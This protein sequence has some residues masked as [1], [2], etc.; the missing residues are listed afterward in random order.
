V[1]SVCGQ[2]Y[3]PKAAADRFA[4]LEATVLIT[5]DGYLFNG[6]T[7]DRRAASL[8]LARALPTL[9]ATILVEHLGLAWPEGGDTGLTVRPRP[10][11][12]PA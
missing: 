5:A 3:V 11:R 12:R 8:E 7:H 9:R 4:Q 10:R 1:W 2:D 6:T